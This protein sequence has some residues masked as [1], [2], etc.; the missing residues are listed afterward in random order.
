MMA[1]GGPSI[2][3]SGGPWIGISRIFFISEETCQRAG[4][5]CFEQSWDRRE[6]ERNPQAQRCKHCNKA[7]EATPEP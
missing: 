6:L 3:P 5:H 7:Q 4:G 2:Y 1:L